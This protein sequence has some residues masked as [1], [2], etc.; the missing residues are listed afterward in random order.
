M[1]DF[2]EDA[3]A[4]IGDFGSAAQLSNSNDKIRFSIGTPGFIA[5]EVSEYNSYGLNC[6]VFSLGCVMH[7]MLF[8]ICPFWDDDKKKR[9]RLLADRDYKFNLNSPEYTSVEKFAKGLSDNCIK[10][11]S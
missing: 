5:P 4:Y 7:S 6:D 9:R 8:A 2:S 10:F 11:L 3:K 1:S